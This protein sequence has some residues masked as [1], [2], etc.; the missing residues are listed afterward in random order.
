ML[1]LRRPGPKPVIVRQYGRDSLLI[2]AN[3]LLAPLFAALG[4]RV[5]LQSEEQI[6]ARIDS[7]TL[8]LRKRGYVLA[9]IETFELPVIGSRTTSAN[10]YRA[11]FQLLDSPASDAT[12]TAH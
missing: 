9:S 4:M 11:T 5:G 7:D 1:F 2:W 10:W 12:P 8:A 3:L 6:K